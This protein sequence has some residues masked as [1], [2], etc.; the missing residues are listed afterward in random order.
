MR[1]INKKFLIPA[2]V[3]GVSTALWPG[4]AIGLC[5]LLLL[6][7]YLRR[8]SSLWGDRNPFKLF[9]F[10]ISIRLIIITVFSAMIAVTG[11]DVTLF[12][13][14]NYNLYVSRV[15][16]MAYS[17]YW[18]FN[19][20]YLRPGCYAYT[21]L[22]WIFGAVH[23]VAGYSPF[24][25]LL[26]NIT[27]G[28]LAAWMIYVITF[29][30]TDSRRVA[31]WAMGFTIFWPSQILWSVHFLKEAVLTF[32]MTVIIYLFVDMIQRKRWYNLLIILLICLPLGQM[33]KQMHLLA[34]ATV[35]LS[36]VL[37]IPRR[38]WIRVALL[39]IPVAAAMMIAGPSRVQNL[40][41]GFQGKVITTQ[42]G[43]I[44]TGGA[45]YRFIPDRYKP[46]GGLGSLMTPREMAAC[47]LKAVYY[48][49]GA[50]NPFR[51]LGL[52]KL[53]ALPQMV[54][55]YPMIILFLPLGV[56]YLLKYR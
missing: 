7:V 29:R 26:I 32:L 17:G 37:C 45:W 31:A 1:E 50:P 10:G 16:L 30:I 23:L 39:V 40:Y 2:A 49:M 13:D 36:L 41:S 56:L 12:G 44:S 38:L 6:V 9:L 28:C 33:R 19:I 3:L 53:P 11:S 51:V 54:L 46:K 48:Y 4:P 42:L 27:A 55:W 25:I 5:A 14:S 43:Y 18:D 52:N 47:Y 24:L 8:I 22:H 21:I 35:M 15:A 34:L 20:A